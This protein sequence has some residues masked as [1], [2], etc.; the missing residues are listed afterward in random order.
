MMKKTNH[1]NIHKLCVWVGVVVG[2]DL[3]VAGFDNYI[4]PIFLPVASHPPH[5]VSV[6]VLNHENVPAV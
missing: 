6:L 2:V 4:Q 3:G 5:P 1:T